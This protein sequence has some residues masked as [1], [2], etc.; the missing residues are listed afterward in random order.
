MP[1]WRTIVVTACVEPSVSGA[2]VPSAL[3][4]N[5]TSMAVRQDALALADLGDI[6]AELP[7]LVG[8]RARQH[9][10]RHSRWVI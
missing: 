2:S 8:H 6:I 1:A 9:L 10:Q 5:A 3:V 4:V 7:Q